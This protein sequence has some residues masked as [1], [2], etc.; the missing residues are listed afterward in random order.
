MRIYVFILFCSAVNE[1]VP[2]RSSAS[3]PG[4]SKTVI[5]KASAISLTIENC[6][7]NSGSLFVRLDLYSAY[8]SCLNVG[9]GVS[10]VKAI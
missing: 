1:I 8:C 10:K 6:C 2:I 4:S 3:Y 7:I 9:L 5:S